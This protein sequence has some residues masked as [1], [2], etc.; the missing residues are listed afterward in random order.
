MFQQSVNLQN[1]SSVKEVTVGQVTCAATIWI[2]ARRLLLVLLV[3]S[4]VGD[5]FIAAVLTSSIKVSVLGLFISLVFLC[6]STQAFL[7]SE[8]F[9]SNL[10]PDVWTG[11]RRPVRH[12]GPGDGVPRRRLRPRPACG[13]RS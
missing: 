1:A 4:H 9:E 12:T 2:S 6:S 13:R 11:R 5:Q 8:D 10:D 7:F 3:L